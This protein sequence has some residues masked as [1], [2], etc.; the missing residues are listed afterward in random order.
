MENQSV[1]AARS[2][3]NRALSEYWV[4]HKAKV[5]EIESAREN[6]TEKPQSLPIIGARVTVGV[7]KSTLAHAVLCEANADYP[8]LL[9]VPKRELANEAADNIPGAVVWTPRR[10]TDNAKDLKKNARECDPFGCYQI[11][12][13]ERAGERNHRPAQGFCSQCPNGM[14][15]ALENGDEKKKE[16]AISWFHKHD[17]KA[18]DY[19]PCRYLYVGLP[20]QLKAPMLIITQ[21]AFSDA[22]TDFQEINYS[23]EKIARST[24][25]LVIV[26]ESIQ[27][28]NEIKIRAG[29][30]DLWR[31][32]LAGIAG[33]LE[34]IAEH[35][36]DAQ[37]SA[38]LRN[39]AGFLKSDGDKLLEDLTV[40]CAKGEIPRVDDLKRFKK[41]AGALDLISANGLPWEKISLL[42]NGDYLMPLRAFSAIYKCAKNGTARAE[43]GVIY[44]YE[45][46]PIVEHAAK[47]GS[48]IFLDATM[49]LWLQDIIK[50]NGGEVVEARA[51]ENI[52]V[53]WY[54]GEMYARGNVRSKHFGKAAVERRGQLQRIIKYAHAHKSEDSEGIA[55]LAHRAWFAYSGANGETQNENPA[56]MAKKFGEE[57]YCE[58]GWYGAHDRGHNRWKGFDL[59]LVGMPLISN[60]T[61]ASLYAG[62]RAAAI[63][64]RAGAGWAQW[65]GSI[66]EEVPPLPRKDEAKRFLLDFYAQTVAQGIGRARGVNHLGQML[67]IWIWGGLQVQEMDEALKGQGVKVDLKAQNL[68]H[69]AKEG[70]QQRDLKSWV[71][72]AVEAC[73]V[74]RVNPSRR[75]VEAYLRAAGMQCSSSYIARSLGDLVIEGLINKAKNGRPRRL[76]GPG[77]LIDPPE[78]GYPDLAVSEGSELAFLNEPD[79]C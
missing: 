20:V 12:N 43:K 35:T 53:T 22:V 61:V 64:C 63:A 38:N 47:R 46:S 39:I 1:E 21:Q 58:A 69:V 7:G 25:R 55:L 15:A 6:Q 76:C 49:P 60:E 16:K 71:I 26:D 42:D 9:V 2:I 79:Q 59:V 30:V 66:G 40:Y 51:K 56:E 37:K 18:H 13:V 28:A 34:D 32:R 4:A 8:G 14:R 31:R 5:S 11:G 45:V 24:Q 75:A 62:A 50:G 52:K 19:A 74:A 73:E 23:S 65:D 68:V 10:E 17:L 67:N 36:D 72:A 27:P 54:Q 44:V 41:A 70:R 29:D 33:S 48:T 57:N 78:K 77:L 3:L